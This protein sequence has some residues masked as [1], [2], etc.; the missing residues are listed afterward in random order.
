MAQIPMGRP[1]WGSQVPLR[2]HRPQPGGKLRTAEGP[3]VRQGTQRW[4]ARRVPRQQGEIAILPSPL[5]LWGLTLSHPSQAMS[6]S[7]GK[8]SLPASRG[9]GPQRRHL[10]PPGPSSSSYPG[11][12]IHIPGLGQPRKPHPRPLPFL[13]IRAQGLGVSISPI[14]G[15]GVADEG[16]GVLHKP[17]PEAVGCTLGPRSC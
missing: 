5:H 14:P 2:L 12:G 11:P 3:G 16:A 9:C 4:P 10:S 13:L 1:G 7:P 6:P 8:A 15:V 17:R